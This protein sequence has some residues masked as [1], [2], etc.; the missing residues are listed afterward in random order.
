[1]YET[2]SSLKYLVSYFFLNC[3]FILNGVVRYKNQKS[4]EN[5]SISIKLHRSTSAFRDS[6]FFCIL[7]Y[8]VMYFSNFITK[9]IIFLNKNFSYANHLSFQLNLQTYHEL[10]YCPVLFRNGI[11]LSFLLV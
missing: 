9:F 11:H 4:S 3:M 5:S 8:S 7:T 2:K 10:L 6:F 1:M